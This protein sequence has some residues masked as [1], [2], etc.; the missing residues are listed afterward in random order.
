MLPPPP[1][2][3]RRTY[4]FGVFVLAV[5]SIIFKRQPTL[6][7]CGHDTL[8]AELMV[9]HMVLFLASARLFSEHGTELA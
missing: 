1:P 7:E 2:P 4:R 3:T 6:A 5:T 9:Q 8:G